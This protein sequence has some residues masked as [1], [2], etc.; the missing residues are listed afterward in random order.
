MDSKSRFGHGVRIFAV[1][2]IPLL[3]L[4]NISLLVADQVS[5]NDKQSHIMKNGFSI[6][7]VPLEN[8]TQ[9]EAVEALHEVV[10]KIEDQDIIIVV[11]DREWIVPIRDIN[12]LYDVE[13]TVRET[14]SLTRD[15]RRQ[16]VPLIFQYNRNAMLEILQGIAN[17]MNTPVVNARIVKKGS[18]FE[19]LPEQI[20]RKI[21][22]D[23][24]L[25]TIQ[26]ALGNGLQSNTIMLDLVEVMPK[27]V[28][29]DI[30]DIDKHFASYSTFVET[31]DVK[32]I[33]NIQRAIEQI[34]AVVVKPNEILSFNDH[35]GPYTEANRYVVAP[36]FVEEVLSEGIGGGV[37][38]VS[39]TLYVAGLKAGMQVLEHKSHTRPV[40]YVPLGYDATIIDGKYDLKMTNS[41]RKNLYVAFTYTDQHELI[42]DIYGNQG[43][44]VEYALE[45]RNQQEFLPDR[46]YHLDTTIGPYSE[47]TISEGEKGYKIE[48]YR[49]WDQR[50]Q[51]ELIMQYEYKAVPQV[52]GVGEK[53]GK[54][55][56]TPENK[57][58]QSTKPT[59]TNSKQ[60]K[61][62][63]G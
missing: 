47:K 61:G 39:S 27:V 57:N 1:F 14:F 5:A 48:L 38:Q 24:S 15:T 2:L 37:C 36:V 42:V 21:N 9:E 45:T 18:K 41:K 7:G 28:S 43:D 49:T 51:E 33:H 31:K 34:D 16:N 40:Q 10:S 54:A 53:H 11:E 12:V 22:I 56:D 60:V 25:L 32:R 52:I 46:V 3:V 19:K 17:E 62:Q 6:A 13:S 8:M 63:L 26:S 50:K 29:N 44:Y 4:S 20:G 23:N 58:I 55:K 59:N 35:A 30:R